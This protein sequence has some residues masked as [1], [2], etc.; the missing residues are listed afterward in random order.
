VAVQRLAQFIRGDQLVSFSIA[1]CFLGALAQPVLEAVAAC[2]KLVYFN[3]RLNSLPRDA[4]AALAMAL[5]ECQSLTEVD[6]ASND[7]DDSFGKLFARVLT[8]NRVLWKVDLARN[9]L[10]Q[11]TGR[12]LLQ[13]MRKNSTLTSIGDTVNDFFDL[14]IDNRYQ[15]QCHLEANRRAL[16]GISAPGKA[17][18][19]PGLEDLE[20]KIVHDDPQV[21]EPLAI[22]S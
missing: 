10:E 19:N 12:D 4:G 9:K 16:D 1:D 7:L 22:F 11:E 6:M 14:G 15:I 3:M 8:F 17:A 18:L 5:D 20:W 21:F 13:A 2:R